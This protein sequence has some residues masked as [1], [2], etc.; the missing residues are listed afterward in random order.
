MEISIPNLFLILG[1]KEYE[2]QMLRVRILELEATIAAKPTAKG[3]DNGDGLPD[4]RIPAE[5]V[6]DN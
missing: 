1:Q 6:S 3:A 2:L 5:R 4:E